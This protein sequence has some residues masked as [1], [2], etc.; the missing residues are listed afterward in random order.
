MLVPA[1][2]L[3]LFTASVLRAQSTTGSVSGTVVDAETGAP[4][5]GVNVFAS[6]TTFG[7]ATDSTGAYHIRG[8]PPGPFEIAAS[9]VGYEAERRPV[10]VRAGRDTV[11]VFTLR[12]TMIALGQVEVSGERPRSWRRLLERFEEAFIGT[13]RNARRCKLVNPEVLSFTYE[14]GADRLVAEASAPLVMENR[15]LGYRVEF[16]IAV[17]TSTAR[18]LEWRGALR[19][20]ELEP[21][22]ARER[23]RWVRNRREAYEGSLRHFLALLARDRYAYA[24]FEAS[25]VGRPGGSAATGPGMENAVSALVE[26]SDDD[27]LVALRGPAVLRV[28]YNAF[29]EEG[30]GTYRRT[31]I[32]DRG[33]GRRGGEDDLQ[34][35]WLSL[36]H[37]F[38]LLHRSGRAFGDDA[39]V[40]H[41]YWAWERFAEELPH[42]YEPG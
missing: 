13:T 12:P 32:G 9:M 1:L 24:G 10:R 40:R 22:S 2:V 4:L 26:S 38:A 29:P 41:G 27:E 14:A 15:A 34:V 23:R 6:Y 36:N 11:L 5:V 7:A 37:R 35:S 31:V 20:T 30:Y 28:V 16:H 19:F 42:D 8:L 39:V 18:Q 33:Y 17:F 3:V 25:V 21:R